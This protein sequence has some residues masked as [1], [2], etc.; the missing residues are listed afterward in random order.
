[1]IRAMLIPVAPLA[2]A[3]VAAKACFGAIPFGL[4]NMPGRG[5]GVDRA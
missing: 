1:M 5:A 4:R 3:P 2:D